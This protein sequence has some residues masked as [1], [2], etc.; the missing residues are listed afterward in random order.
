MNHLE[1]WAELDS[2][3]FFTMRNVEL[4]SIATKS[5]PCKLSSRIRHLPLLCI[6]NVEQDRRAPTS[7]LCRMSSS[8]RQ[9]PILYHVECWAELGSNKFSTMKNAEHKST[10][11]NSVPC[12]TSLQSR[13]S[14]RIAQPPLPYMKNDEQDWTIPNSVPCKLSRTTRQLPL[15]FHVECWAELDTATFCTM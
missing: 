6:K 10:V 8:T 5:I 14:S 11:P 12:S 4:I 13:M 3:H 15:L 1:C 2:R 9:G 7:V